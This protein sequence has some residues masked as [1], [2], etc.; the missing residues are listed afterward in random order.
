MRRI[1]VVQMDHLDYL[2][3][4]P[5]N[6]VDVVYFDPMFRQPIMESAS[7]R[8]L[9]GLADDRPLSEKSVQEAIR[10]SRRVV[11]MKE[12]RDSDQFARLGFAEV[13]RSGTKIAYGVIRC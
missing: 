5:E 6:S 11:V 12:H 2:R 3:E 10:A 13:H 8:A 4:L 9:R 7:I 1:E